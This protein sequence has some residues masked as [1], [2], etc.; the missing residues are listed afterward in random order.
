[1]KI[2][3]PGGSG[4]V[5]TM[6]ARAFQKRG[7]EVVVLSR[8][9]QPAPWR[10]ASWDGK[11]PGAWAHEMDGADAVIHLS[12]RTVN[13]RYTPQHR[14]EILESRTLTTLAVGQAIAAAA[15]PPKV[16][17]NASTATLYR[18]SIDKP[19]DEFTGELG[20]N[21]PGVPET[22]GFSVGIGL[23]WEAALTAIP[24]PATRKIALRTSMVMS[25]DKDGVFDVLLGLVRHGLGGTQGPGTQYLSWIHDQDFVRA[26]QFLIENDEV[27]GPVN[28]CAPNPIPNQ[29]FMR[30]IRLA[31]GTQ[32]GLPASKW[33]LEVGAV[34]L[35]T[36]TELILKS[37]RVLP[38]VLQQAGFEFIFPEW[39]SAAQN[40]VRRWR[41]LQG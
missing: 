8:H 6:L 13:C 30:A 37:R 41:N 26:A 31:N 18:H 12:G 32:M 16:W 7:D 2:V 24:T 11:Y 40:L 20:G 22:W 25:P 39:P 38:A 4:Q 10:T 35:R 34:F 23:Q 9:P 36:E 28:I 19:Q 21:E 27:S 29:D 15:C 17:L 3:I 5:G 14:K 1:M 33:M